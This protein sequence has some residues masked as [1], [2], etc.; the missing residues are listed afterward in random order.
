VKQSP[1]QQK[2]FTLIEIAVVLV[3]V[4]LL[5][6]GIMKGQEMINS[7]K[8][9]N[10]GQDLRNAGTYAMAFQDKYRALPGDDASVVAHVSGTAA[11]T[12]GTTGNGRIE[13]NWNSEVATEE[14][15]LFWQHVRLAGLANGTTNTTNLAQ[16]IPRNANGG[17]IGVTSIAPITGWSGGLFSC[18]AG[19]TGA[20]ARQLDTMMDDGS[21]NT[22][23]IRVVAAG[24]V[25]TGAGVALNTSNDAELYTLC[26]SM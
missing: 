2:G 19:V 23:S 22:G 17:A 25:S 6:G 9:K 13:G 21:T 20:V 5:I 11:T 15:F 16:Y 18:T 4:G 12:G 14:S 10:L 24:T 1:I 8:V 7:G 3:I 26:M